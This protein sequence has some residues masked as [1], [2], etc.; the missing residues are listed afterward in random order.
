MKNPNAEPDRDADY[1]PEP[2]PGVNRATHCPLCSVA[3]ADHP[4]VGETCAARHAAEC[5]ASGLRAR[6]GF[7]ERHEREWAWRSCIICAL[8]ARNREIDALR[9]ELAARDVEDDGAEIFGTTNK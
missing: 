3:W 5:R 7:C 6:A 4:G 8:E 9:A 2:P 1:Q